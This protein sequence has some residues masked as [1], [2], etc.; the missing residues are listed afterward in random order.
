MLS[1]KEI[2]FSYIEYK[3]VQHLD[4]SNVTS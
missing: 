3:N 4:V 1:L 2:P